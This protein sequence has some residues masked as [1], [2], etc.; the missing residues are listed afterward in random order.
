VSD[1][2]VGGGVAQ[3]EDGTMHALMFVVEH[4]CTELNATVHVR[5]PA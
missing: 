2:G 1:H 3:L 5:G 4:G